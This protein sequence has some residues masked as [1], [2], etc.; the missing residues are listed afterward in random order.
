MYIQAEVEMIPEID[1][2]ITLEKWESLIE[3]WKKKIIKQA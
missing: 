2:N 1:E 3:L